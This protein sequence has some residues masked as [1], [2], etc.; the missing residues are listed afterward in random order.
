MAR[1]AALACALPSSVGRT[2]TLEH[3]LGTGIA[4]AVAGDLT[5][6]RGLAKEATTVRPRVARARAVPPQ[7][8]H[9]AAGAAALAAEPL[10]RAERAVNIQRACDCATA[11]RRRPLAR[12]HR[13]ARLRLPPQRSAAQRPRARCAE[14]ELGAAAEPAAGARA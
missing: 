2:I 9:R 4:P 7:P 14:G 12:A 8:E 11:I 13:G 3:A 1:C 6:A 5:L 10:L